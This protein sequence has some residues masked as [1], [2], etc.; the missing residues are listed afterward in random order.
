MR[1]VLAAEFLVAIKRLDSLPEMECS[2]R[3]AMSQTSPSSAGTY[4]YCVARAQPFESGESPFATP[5][6]GGQDHAARVVTYGDL[7]AVVSDSPQDRYDLTR[8]NLLAHQRVIDEAMA[9]SDVLPVSFGMVA[10]S[11]QEVQEK[12]LKRES[13]HLHRALEYVQGRIELELKVSWNEER[14]FA[15]IVAE[16]DDIRALRDSI[17]GQSPEATHY[18]RVQ[19]G[20]LTAASIQRKSEAE[21]ASLLEALQPLAVETRVNEN[22]TDMMLLNAAFLVDKTRIEEFDATVQDLG[23]AQAG[24]MIFQYVGPLPPYSFVDVRVRWEDKP[25]GSAV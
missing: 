22:Q 15:A 6:I 18:E 5:G 20:E 2:W 13:D 8:E 23:E 24:R 3:L 10:D 9:R 25:V 7:A 17:A 11:D 16:N 21:A 12:L 4:I 19:L 1:E 14:L